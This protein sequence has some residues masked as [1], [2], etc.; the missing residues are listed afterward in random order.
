MNGGDHCNFPTFSKSTVSPIHKDDS[1]EERTN[2]RPISV[3][4][5]VSRL[6]EKIIY[7]QV[8]TYFKNVF[9]YSDHQGFRQFRSVLTCLI[10]CTKDWYLNFDKGYYSGVIFI[11][12][13][14]IFIDSGVIFIDSGVIFIDRL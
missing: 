10:K 4:H 5:V 11:D 6:F 2:Y 3:L 13:G 14:V 7:Y 12:S 1:T 8:F 9:F